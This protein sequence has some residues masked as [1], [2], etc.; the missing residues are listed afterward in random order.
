M[1]INVKSSNYDNTISIG[2]ALVKSLKPGAVV[3]LIGELGAGKTVLIKGMAYGLG[4]DPHLVTSPT[5]T[6]I[7][8][9]E[10]PKGLFLYHFDLYRLEEPEQLL[11]IGAK[12]YFWDENI[13]AVE[14]ANLFLT[15]IP[16][17]SILIRFEKNTEDE[18]EKRVIQ[19]TWNDNQYI[20]E[21]NL[22]K[23]LKELNLVL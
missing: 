22:L 11:E 10:G 14:W 21:E 17:H 4:I 2:V 9:Y 19:I 1:K 23:D 18:S 15:E 13:C 20:A 3:G 12:E 7:N 16:E 6:L 8:E 5:F